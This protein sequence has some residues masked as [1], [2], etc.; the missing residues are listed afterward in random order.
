MKHHG[1]ATIVGETTGGGAHTIDFLVI[2]EGFIISL[3]TGYAVHPVTGGNWEGVGVDPDIL[4]PE[5]KAL[6]AAHLHA[7]ENLV[8]KAKDSEKIRRLEWAL[9]RTKAKYTPLLVEIQIL[10]RYEGQYRGYKVELED[11]ILSMKGDDPRD[12]WK[13]T[14]ITETLFAV[15][16]E[17]NARFVIEGEEKASAFVFIH[18]DSGR[19]STRSRV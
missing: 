12:D 8:K 4:V 1:R 6:K 5:E 11:G 9:K 19:E 2:H 18:R 10:S 7:F 14:P 15:D 3:P 17:Y 13:M 16:D